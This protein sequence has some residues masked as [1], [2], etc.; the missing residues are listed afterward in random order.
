MMSEVA[1]QL[2]D[3]STSLGHSTQDFILRSK[4]DRAEKVPNTPAN[5]RPSA[6][7]LVY[8]ASSTARPQRS[9]LT[10]IAFISLQLSSLLA[11][12]HPPRAKGTG[13][14]S[15]GWTSKGRLLK[16]C[17]KDNLWYFFV[18]SLALAKAYLQLLRYLQGVLYRQPKGAFSIMQHISHPVHSK[19]LTSS[20]AEDFIADLCKLTRKRNWEVEK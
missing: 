19:K 17:L 16:V 5:L 15:C 12:M 13:S 20:I 14:S 3:S 4:E 7:T 11:L 8:K 6:Y 10:P 18:D 9:A 2:C 1:K